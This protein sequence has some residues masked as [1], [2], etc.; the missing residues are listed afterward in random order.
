MFLHLGSDKVVPLKNIIAITDMKILK[1]GINQNFI[2]I[3]R[4][5]KVVED[6][7]ED[8]AKSFII[9]DNKVYLS[10]ISTLTLKKRAETLREDSD[11]EQ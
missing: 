10:A 2:K 9:A 8:N 6:I 4:S 5:E 11:E 7:S 3:K 1:S